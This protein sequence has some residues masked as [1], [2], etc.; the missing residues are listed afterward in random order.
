MILLIPESET[1]FRQPNVM[2]LAIKWDAITPPSSAAGR[3]KKL[4]RN[5]VRKPA[6]KTLDWLYDTPAGLETWW[7]FIESIFR[8]II[9]FIWFSWRY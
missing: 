7:F 3:N 2:D 1:V 8:L 9:L 5:I 6:E 4:L